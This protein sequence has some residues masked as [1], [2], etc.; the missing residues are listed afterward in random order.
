MIVL[1]Y[2]S[3]LRLGL[4]LISTSLSSSQYIFQAYIIGNF[5]TAA[6]NADTS[7]FMLN[8]IIAMV[9]FPIF[10]FIM[11][12]NVSIRAK[13]ICAINLEIK[14]DMIDF[15]VRKKQKKIDVSKD[16]SFMTN[17]LKLL[18]TNG[19]NAEL[20][21]LTNVV[22]FLLAIVASLYYDI[23]TTMAFFL[24][25][26]IP[27]IISNLTQKRIREKSQKWSEETSI[28]TSHLKDA[29]MGIKTIRTYQAE[30][31]VTLRVTSIA[32]RM[33]NA[34]KEMNLMLGFVNTIIIMMA[35]LC[36]L[37][38]PFGIGI[39]RIIDKSLAL[40]SFISVVQ[41]SN[42]I[43]KPLLSILE[44]R[45]QLQTTKV[46][47]RRVNEAYEDR[48]LK[49][50]D[51]E[52]KYTNV[53][54]EMTPF[55]ALELQDLNI[56][57]GSKKLISDLS[58]T[59]RAG[60]KILIMA[61]SGFGKST[62]LRVLQGDKHAAKG[63]YTYN[64]LL[65][66]DYDPLTLREQFSFIL[67]APF[68]FNDTVRFNVTL[69]CSFP[70]KKVLSALEQAGLHQFISEKG[71]DYVI[72]ENGENLSG[73]ELQ[74]LE[75]ARA[76]LYDRPIILAD[77]ATSSLDNDTA[78]HIRKTFINGANTLIEVAHKIPIEEQVLYDKVIHLDD[79]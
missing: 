70:E 29:L 61:P 20:S 14:R 12:C 44:M 72:S 19:I 31:E 62:L 3:K 4:F 24:G 78:E 75:I 50:L 34:L 30:N 39:Y 43:N 46:I 6:T 64:G 53:T 57:L 52:N 28:F 35:T 47:L 25:S 59:V 2:G 27:L 32:E 37:T 79:C 23:W 33:E 8:A 54:A 76:F 68:V 49:Y 67:Q 1:R 71:L 56:Q 65:S 51:Q 42:Y 58:L 40:G 55:S 69:G 66:S 13:C 26:F 22:T 15:L 60:E 7:F 41:L 74:R 48:K 45:N 63:K 5:I 38:L 18:E 10:G 17:D 77:E 73:G 9:G 21:I 36:A 16:L 11:M